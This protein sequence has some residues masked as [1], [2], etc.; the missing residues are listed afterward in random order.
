[1]G[2]SEP[3]VAMDNVVEVD[4][5][6]V[7]G[8]FDRMSRKRRAKHQEAGKDNKVAVIGLSERDG[9]AKLTVIGEKTFKDVV[10]DH[11]APSAIVITD[12]HK[13]YIGLN[14][15]YQA[16]ESVNHYKMET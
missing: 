16:H 1:M 11:V 12:A 2:D 5:T 15:E 8:K 9:K 3:D 13:G 10:R 14:E 7:G 6:Y 4:E